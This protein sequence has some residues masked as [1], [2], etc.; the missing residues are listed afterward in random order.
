MAKLAV[1]RI[2]IRRKWMGAIHK[3]HI[4]QG[5][6]SPCFFR[7]HK[8]RGKRCSNSKIFLSRIL[9]KEEETV[10][11]HTVKV[12]STFLI[13]ANNRSSSIKGSFAIP[14]C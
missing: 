13:S 3:K 7:L 1:E 5:T 6:V 8:R 9:E 4:A 14:C 12:C 11:F 10:P 2:D